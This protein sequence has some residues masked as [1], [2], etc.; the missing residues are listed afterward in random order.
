MTTALIPD[1]PEYHDRIILCCDC[2]K[3]FGW[4]TEQQKYFTNLQLVPPKRCAPCRA[5]R[6]ARIIPAPRAGTLLEG[7]AKQ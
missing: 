1:P 4:T 6:K 2:S 5:I 3:P 7:E